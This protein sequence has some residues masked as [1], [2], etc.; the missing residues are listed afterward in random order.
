MGSVQDNEKKRLRESLKRKVS[1]KFLARFPREIGHISQ[2][3]TFV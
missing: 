2:G 3:G 1:S